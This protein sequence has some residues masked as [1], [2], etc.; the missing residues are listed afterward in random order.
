MSTDSLTGRIANI[1]K[2]LEAVKRKI[3]GN[4]KKF[5]NAAGS[6][7]D[8]DAEEFKDRVRKERERSVSDRVE[9]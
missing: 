2:E 9:L 1:E 7:K 3:S 6:W 4:R 8:I 5:K